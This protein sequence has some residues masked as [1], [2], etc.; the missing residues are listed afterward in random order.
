MSQVRMPQTRMSQVRYYKGSPC[1][2]DREDDLAAWD[3]YAGLFNIRTLADLRKLYMYDVIEK[4]FPWADSIRAG[5]LPILRETRFGGNRELLLVTQKET[6]VK[7]NGRFRVIPSRQGPPKGSRGNGDVSALDTA[8]RELREET[9]ID[10]LSTTFTGEVKPC[11]FIARR[12][13]YGVQELIIYFVVLFE[14]R[15][16]VTIE[17][18]ELDNYT[19]HDMSRGLSHIKDV[20]QPTKQLLRTLENI[21]WYRYLSNTSVDLDTI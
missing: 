14:K 2:S 12:P 3:E 15:P 6:A 19:W 8:I 13:E 9:G 1:G 17:T 21:N 7:N 11:A 16:D 10:I 20:T 4:V 5:F 18:R